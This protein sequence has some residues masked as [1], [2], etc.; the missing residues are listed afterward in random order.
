MFDEFEGRIDRDEEASSGELIVGAIAR[1]QLAH[2][3]RV[4]PWHCT[5]RTEH[6]GRQC[7][8]EV[9][10]RESPRQRRGE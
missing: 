9:R 5:A 8:V 10:L 4:G 7:D 2:V 6:P 3:S 1:E